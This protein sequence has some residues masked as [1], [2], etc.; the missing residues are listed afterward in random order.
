MCPGLTRSE[1]HE[2]ARMSLAG[3]PRSLW[4]DADEVA[5]QGLAD[6][7]AGRVVS[8]PGV[9][10][11]ALSLLVRALPRPALRRVSR[12]VSGPRRR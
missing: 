6:A 3:V 10:W 1:F 9:Q 7:A 12:L 11:R 2:R 4:L 8:V 5:R